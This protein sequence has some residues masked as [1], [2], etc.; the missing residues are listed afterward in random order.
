MQVKK[1]LYIGLLSFSLIIAI[2]IAALVWFLFTNRAMLVNQ[3]VLISLA[4]IAVVIFAILGLGIVGIVI[5][6]IR[7][8]SVPSLETVTVWANE[9]LFP[10]A[11][12]TGKFFGIEKDKILKSFISVNN[13]L[14]GNKKLAL[15][16][17]DIMILLPHCLQNSECKFKITIDVENCKNCGKC[18]ISQ[19]REL[20]DRYRVKLRVATGGTLARKWIEENHP[21]AVIAIACERDLSS[22]IQ[23]TGQLPVLG[24]LN[25]RPNG[26]CINTDVDVAE[27]ERALL[28]LCKGG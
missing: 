10:L 4:F 6:I 24:V 8:K 20:A 16:Y 11:L 28:T 5:M 21:K 17:S 26:P 15:K 25:C 1:R 18:K 12:L 9:L 23:D 13:Y 27:I 2:G 7:S 19:L 3:V 14:V 22:G